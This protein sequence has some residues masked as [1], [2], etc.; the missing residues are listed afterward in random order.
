MVAAVS[1]SPALTASRTRIFL[2]FSSRVLFLNNLGLVS[3]SMSGNHSPQ[4]LQ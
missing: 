3:A 4:R 2:I 1:E